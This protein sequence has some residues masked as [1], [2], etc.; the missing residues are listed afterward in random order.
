VS[1]FAS[2]NAQVKLL[3]ETLAL[4]GYKLNNAMKLLPAAL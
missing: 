4:Q 2:A 3:L 1:Y